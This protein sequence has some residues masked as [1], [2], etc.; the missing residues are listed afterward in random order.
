MKTIRGK[1]A[2]VTGAGSGIGRALALALAQNGAALFLIDVNPVTLDATA[3]DARSHGTEVSTYTCDLAEPAE[4]DC[5]L[6]ALTLDWRAVDILINCAGIAYYGPTHNMTP[7]QW[8]RL[9]QVNLLAPIRLIDALLPVMLSRDE[10]HILNVCSLFGLIP[11]RR[12]AAYQTTKFGLIGFTQALRCEYARYGLG[13]TALCPG[14]TRTAMLETAER[15]IPD[16]ALP[17][18][19][20]WFIT[21]PER[22]A[23][24][25]IDA[26]RRNRGLVVVSAFAHLSWWATR[27]SPGLVGW[28]SRE[29]WRGP[30]KIDV[31]A[32]R[33]ARDRSRGEIAR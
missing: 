27:L 17:V 3:S 29:G 10:A 13:V 31:A 7:E 30:G 16:K 1:K 24:R 25:G 18:P 8:R 5:A 22:V 19:S 6:K 32:D 9:L 4:I 28:I 21:T 20:G 15:G 14:V 33:A 11:G 2:V 26:I 12:L 23:A